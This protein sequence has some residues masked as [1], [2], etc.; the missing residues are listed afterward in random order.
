M[1]AQVYARS[2]TTL[3]QATFVRASAV[4]VPLTIE[5]IGSSSA[6][7]SS[8]PA[9]HVE[10]YDIVLADEDGVVVVPKAAVEDVLAQCERGTAADAK[11]LADL[12]QGSSL[13]DA[14]ARHR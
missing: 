2:H 8:F 12:Q 3:G 14:F 4:Q 7:G 13:G 10:P 9:T 6:S 1:Y 5:P 11:V